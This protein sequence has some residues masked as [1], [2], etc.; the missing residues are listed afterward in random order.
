M[1]ACD[2]EREGAEPENAEAQGRAERDEE[3]SG[4]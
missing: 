4:G 3:Q 1:D 2:E